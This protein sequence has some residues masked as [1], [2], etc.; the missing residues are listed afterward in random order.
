MTE[1][2]GPCRIEIV[3]WIVESKHPFAIVKDHGFRDLMKTGC[4]EY[5]LPLPATVSWD[6]KHVF[7][8]MWSQLAAKLKVNLL[9]VWPKPKLNMKHRHTM[10]TWTLQLMPG[11]PLMAKRSLLWPH[12]M[13]WTGLPRLSFLTLWSVHIH[14]W[15]RT[16]Q[17]HLRKSWKTSVSVTRCTEKKEK[18]YS[19]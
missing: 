4:P 19:T 16:L 2:F 5:Q 12:T 10:V 15:G 14:I 11:P 3:C 13:R 17:R 1:S 9:T 18:L 8:S 7:V 6:M